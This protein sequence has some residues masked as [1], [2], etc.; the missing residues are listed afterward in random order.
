MKIVS[1]RP[2]RWASCLALVPLIVGLG[3]CLQFGWD[4]L[5]R[6]VPSAV[7]ELLEHAPLA[8]DTAALEAI[9]DGERA[10]FG[11]SGRQTL[12]FLV[13]R[14]RQ[15]GLQPM[16]QDGYLQA[17]DV[18]R[19]VTVDAELDLAGWHARAGDELVI[20]SQ[21]PL[22]RLERAAPSVVFVGFGVTAPE[23]GRDDYHGLDLR[24]RVA[25][26][27]LGDPDRP[28][29]SELSG[30]KA[31]ADGGSM[32]PSPWSW[33]AQWRYKVAEAA[34]HGAA[35][36]ILVHDQRQVGVDWEDGRRRFPAVRLQLHRPVGT[37]EASP[38]SSVDFVALVP[39]AAGEHLL[40]EAS[41]RPSRALEAARDPRFLGRVLEL[42]IEVTID[43]EVGR[44]RSFNVVGEIPGRY[45]ADQSVVIAAD[46]DGGRAGAQ[47]C[48]GLLA[49]AEA[50]HSLAQEPAR[51]VEFVAVTLGTSHRLGA[52]RYAHRPPRAM[53]ECAAAFVLD[54]AETKTC[55]LASRELLEVLKAAAQVDQHETGDGCADRTWPR[56][57]ALAF[58]RR[59]VP[60]V[61]VGSGLQDLRMVLRAGYRLAQSKGG[62]RWEPDSP[63]RFCPRSNW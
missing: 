8:E 44:S 1:W 28:V 49:L 38:P 7:I 29:L 34:R 55:A 2:R 41:I 20:W 62:P 18:D 42:P 9:G 48:A 63:F 33:Y 17:V 39:A 4:R 50:F 5:S 54:G 37:A 61:V 60:S 11:E 13:R 36:V 30:E 19:I 45:D 56:S 25:L 52:E 57:A 59:G 23:R 32:P 15:A 51:S 35:G 53:A 43:S 31:A 27:W 46:W 10:A 12:K 6:K 47:A 58:A 40:R 14:F 16:G 24:G 22:R 21:R 26:V 3:G